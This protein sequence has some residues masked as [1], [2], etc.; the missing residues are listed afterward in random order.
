MNVRNYTPV[1]IKAGNN[2]VNFVNIT[3][4]FRNPIIHNDR[5]SLKFLCTSTWMKMI[6]DY[7]L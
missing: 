4:K 3:L 7:K 2:L 5:F 1:R 6:R